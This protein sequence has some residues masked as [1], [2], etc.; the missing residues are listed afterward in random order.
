ME[1]RVSYAVSWGE[2]LPN[3]NLQFPSC[4]CTSSGM[5]WDGMMEVTPDHPNYTLWLAEIN[6]NAPRRA[7]ARAEE[8]ERQREHRERRNKSTRHAPSNTYR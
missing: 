5:L 6:A 1:E 4:G 2:V 8:E 7:A 3:G